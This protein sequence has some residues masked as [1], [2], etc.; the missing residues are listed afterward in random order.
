M[1][2]GLLRSGLDSWVL[3]VTLCH[4]ILHSSETR[5]LAESISIDWVGSTDLF[6]S[7]DSRGL[8]NKVTKVVSCRSGYWRQSIH[9][10]NFAINQARR[11]EG[12]ETNKI[13]QSNIC[14]AWLMFGDSF[15]SKTF[16]HFLSY[17]SGCT[18][19]VTTWFTSMFSSFKSA[20]HKMKKKNHNS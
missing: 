13:T 14:I 15:R 20:Q 11:L 7:S 3:Y 2:Y 10:K 1:N 17:N 4:I 18:W 19:R 8:T 16:Y 6:F 12:I 5:S 9:K